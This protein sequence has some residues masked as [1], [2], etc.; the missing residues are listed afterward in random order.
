MTRLLSN[1]LGDPQPGFSQRIRQ[2]ECASGEPGA[3][4]RLSSEIMQRTQSKIREL[5]LDP[6][7]T[8]SAELYL[9]LRQRLLADEKRLKDFLGLGSES[10]VSSTDI[11]SSV[12]QFSSK[13]HVPRTCFALKASVNK[14]L[15]KSLPP[16]KAMSGLKYRSV[17]SLIKH[18]PVAQIRVASLLYEAARWHRDF[19]EQYVGLTP[20][21]FE[22]RP[23]TVL[24]PRAR[25]WEKI[26]ETFVD[27]HRHTSAVFKELGTIVTLPVQADVPALAI[28]SLLLL[29]D[30]FNSIRCASTFL[31]L[32]QV[33]ADFGALVRDIATSE[34]T[35]SA[36]F[37][38]QPLSWRSVQY[39][40]HTVREAYHPALFEPHVQPEDLTLVEAEAAL[41]EAIPALAF[42][43]DTAGL[44]CV[45]HG[46]AVS[47]NMLDVALSTANSLEFE[48]RIVKHVRQQVWSDIITR[49]LRHRNLDYSLIEPLSAQPESS[50]LEAG[51]M[52]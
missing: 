50:R 24:F 42:W 38:G 31:K 14:R 29:L 39:Y 35:T 19:F 1:L 37:A 46:Q 26:A 8:T 43:Q 41:A 34:P 6:L 49:Y 32:Q 21:D 47:L 12:L 7:D 45:D 5:G 23:I 51:V 18:E 44:A 13:M 36:D 16:K 3:D 28:T 30:G 25:R 4:I 40:Y 33:T 22:S 52:A 27:Q 2:L 20:S 48:Q 17:D 10:D 15:L 11:L 9:A